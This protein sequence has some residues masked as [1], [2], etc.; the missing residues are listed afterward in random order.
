VVPEVVAGPNDSAIFE[1]S[2]RITEAQLRA[3]LRAEAPNYQSLEIFTL[4]FHRFCPAF[5]ERERGH[6]DLVPQPAT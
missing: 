1:I 4:L 3:M 6:H 2:R 5:A